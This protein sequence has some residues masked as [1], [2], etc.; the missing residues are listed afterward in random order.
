VY[1]QWSA[2]SR[3]LA[4]GLIEREK[5]IGPHGIPWADALD[6]DND[7]WFEVREEIDYA[8]KPLDEW[9][10]EHQGKDIDPGTR[11]VVVD[12]RGERDEV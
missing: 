12:T 11:V 9:H 4:E 10:K 7:G 3:A 1:F 2:R 6:P 8:Q 5:S